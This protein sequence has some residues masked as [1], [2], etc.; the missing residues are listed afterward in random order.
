MDVSLPSDSVHKVA[1][2]LCEHLQC[3]VSEVRRLFLVEDMVDTL[4]V[5]DCVLIGTQ[6]SS[7]WLPSSVKIALFIYLLVD[8][9]NIC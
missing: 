5:C 4:K 2:Q 8:C 1:D 6:F 7:L 3:S 9:L